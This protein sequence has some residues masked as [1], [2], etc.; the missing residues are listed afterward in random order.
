MHA[1]LKISPLCTAVA[2][3]TKRRT[4]GSVANVKEPQ[5]VMET[6][7]CIHREICKLELSKR[8]HF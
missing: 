3:F 6:K 4:E 1:C 5:D 8:R 2:V 7:S